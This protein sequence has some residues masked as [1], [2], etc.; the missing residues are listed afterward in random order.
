MRIIS[1]VIALAIGFI[2]GFQSGKATTDE[3]KL[4]RLNTHATDARCSFRLVLQIG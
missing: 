1:L 4:T 3:A 2:A